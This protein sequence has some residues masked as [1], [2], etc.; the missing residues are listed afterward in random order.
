VEATLAEAKRVHAARD[1]ASEKNRRRYGWGS[2]RAID[3]KKR[4]LHGR[5]ADA[6]DRGRTPFPARERDL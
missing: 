4:S 3:G 5:G 2:R 6:V 1:E